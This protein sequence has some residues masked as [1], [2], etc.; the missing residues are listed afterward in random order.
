MSAYIKIRKWRPFGATLY[1]HK[2][3]LA[4]GAFI[5]LLTIKTPIDSAILVFG[6]FSIILGHELGHAWMAKRFG[7]D[8][9]EIYISYFHGKC[10]FEAPH[11]EW[12]EVVIAWGGVLVQLGI[13]L[14]VFVIAIFWPE[15]K[16]GH[17][18]G[19]LA[20]MGVIN[21]VIA[22]FNL[23]PSPG[24]DGMLAWR[25]F[26]LFLEKR[27]TDRKVKTMLNQVFRNKQD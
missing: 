23:V 6:Y 15:P 26:P 8:V 4:V 13:A 5:W 7:L 11:Y 16:F 19:V 18:G 3:S 10:S 21:F 20:V 1:L 27:K 14:T 9:E 12:D 24:L 17:F 2:M 25:V 22:M